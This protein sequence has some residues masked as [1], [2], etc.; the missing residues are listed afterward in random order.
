MGSY[1][2]YYKNNKM[3]NYRHFLR[4]GNGSVLIS[5]FL[6]R[7]QNN[8]NT[9]TGILFMFPAG[10]KLFFTGGQNVFN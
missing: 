10:G 6:V 8:K 9:R 4:L 7:F 1:P 3:I 5:R 2:L